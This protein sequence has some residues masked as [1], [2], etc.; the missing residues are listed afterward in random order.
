[1]YWFMQVVISHGQGL[2]Q[3]NAFLNKLGVLR[4]SV[5]DAAGASQVLHKCI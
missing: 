1:M 4:E 3:C 2:D 5:D